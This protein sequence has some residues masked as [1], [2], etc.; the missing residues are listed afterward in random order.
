MWRRIA[1]NVRRLS[2][3]EQALSEAL[4]AAD[5][6]N[7]VKSRFLANMSHE[8]RTPL[9]GVLGMSE[10]VLMSDLT[11]PQ[12]AQVGVIKQS[13]EHLLGMIERILEMAHIDS[14]L[15]EAQAQPFDPA[16][17]LA[18]VAASLRDKAIAKNLAM[19]EAYQPI[20]L[21]LGDERRLSKVLHAIVDNAIQFTRHGSVRLDLASSAE[22]LVFT[23][24]DTGVG[25]TPE[26]QSRLF[27]PFSQG[28]DSATRSV[29]GAGLSLALVQRLLAS[30]GGTIEY[31][32]REGQGTTFRIKVP[33]R[34]A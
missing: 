26:T 14:A 25:M 28:D 32:T 24:T 20:G 3:S 23:V 5:T 10:I 17:A 9:N 29:D 21:F 34:P 6:A 15:S 4:K 18:Q 31:D 19:V 16:A 30:M 27:T 33:A 2:T 12:R 8:L 11:E 7:V 13:G 22:G 1:A